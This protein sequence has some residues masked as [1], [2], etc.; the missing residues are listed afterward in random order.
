MIRVLAVLVLA[1]ATVAVAGIREIAFDAASCAAGKTLFTQL[2]PGV[3]GIVVQNTY[4]DP[5]MWGKRYREYMGGA[6]GSGIAVGDYDGDGKVDLFVSTKTKPGR[7][8]RNLGHWKFADVTERAGLS[9]NDSVLSAGLGWLKGQLGSESPSI[10]HQGATFADV[11]N[12]GRPDLYVCRNNAPNLLYMNNGDGT[13][14]EE[15]AERGLALVDGSVVGA[16][17]DYD[18]DGR[19]D[20]FVL[21]NQVNGTEPSGRADHLFHNDGTGH[22]TE[23]TVQAGIKGGTFGHSATW[24]DY[25]HDGWPDLYI[26]NDFGGPDHL[27]RN[28]HDGTFTD[29]LDAVVP[30]TSYSSMGADTA[31]LNN[32]GYPDLFVADMAT[33]NREQDRRGLAASRESMLLMDLNGTHAPQYMRN[34]LLLNTGR[35]VFQEA[36]C[37]AGIA[38]TGWTWSV[39]FE[40]FDNDGWVD[41]HVTNGMV[42][43]ANNSD[44]LN[45]MMQA[46]SDAGRI[47]TMKNTPVLNEPHLAYR[48]RNGEGFDNVSAA[49]GLNETGVSFG[50]ATGDFDNDGDLDLVYLNYDGGVSVF[51]NDVANQHRIQVRLR[52]K[53]SNRFGVGAVI[54][55][56]SEAGPQM[57]TLTVSRGYASGSE[58]V[59]HF[60]LGRDLIVK[61]LSVEW[62]SG[63]TQSFSSLAADRAY[64]IEEEDAPSSLSSTTEIVPNALYVVAGSESGAR[65]K[66]ASVLA[67]PDKEQIFLPFR[68]DQRG[69]GIVAGDVD[70]DGIEDLLVTATPGSPAQLLHA[71]NGHYAGA[72]LPG[73]S[74]ASVEDGPALLLDFDGDGSRDLLVT[75]TGAHRDSWPD[76]YQPVLYANDGHGHFTRSDLLPKMAV[77][78]G[79]ICAADWDGDGDLDLFI[80]ARSVPGRY[81]E[82]PHSYLLRREGAHFVDVSENAPWLAHLG[83]VKSALFRDVDLD[84]RPDLIVASEWDFVRYFHNDGGGG[85]SDRTERAGFA[86]GGRG[87][88]N[89]LA[90]ADLNGDGRPDF[91]AGNL[92]LNTTYAATRDHPTLL[93]SGDFANDGT[94]LLI[95]A[96]YGG[97]NVYPVRSR[98][99]LGN[100]LPFVLR[101]FPRN[102]DFARATL[103]SVVGADALATAEVFK[104]DQFSSGAFLSQPDGTYR[105]TSFPRIAQIGP[106]QGIVAAD[107]DG[108]G[109]VDVC[110]VQ[111]SYNALPHFDGGVGIFL[112]GAGDGTFTA[113][114]PAASGVIVPGNA[115]A[116][117]LIGS[118]TG[119][120][121]DLFVTR[122]SGTSELLRNQVSGRRWLSLRLVGTPANRDAIGAR[123][124]VAYSDG[125]QLVSEIGAGGGWLSQSA[126]S[127]LIATSSKKLATKVT[128]RW[129]EGAVTEHLPPAEQSGVWLVK[130][131]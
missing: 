62:P 57:R 94:K 51:R 107:L 83:L 18:R 98:G 31:D 55:I 73:L 111:N 11:D 47:R 4:D 89:S 87:W 71:E 124:T 120:R 10:W 104:A 42:R 101:R 66:D 119:A 22:F 127:L 59:A 110:A 1:H 40:D 131:K 78:A 90:S 74:G 79:A 117:V 53:R 121:P 32:D 92:G 95:E 30:H 7:L 64:L 126:S 13:F 68:T 60:G 38:A 2:P 36:A 84:G 39:L 44:I 72:P 69:P 26:A 9:E 115:K 15:A 128:V 103:S 109:V 50:A 123:V 112:K 122:F 17:C 54:R 45:R 24:F 86:S 29:V 63:A 91:V 113:I 97:E 93:Y 5:Q 81:P 106:M 37:W 118:D 21:T 43:E 46:E 25:D 12:D 61:R 20:V 19:L 108:D 34:S 88:W 48:N 76:G 67:S 16:F 65:I 77:N 80:G 49:W 129:P 82:A 102:D 99:D 28:N 35:G 100:R 58:L 96:A 8:F 23:T 70:G 116:L 14:R 3:T 41:L 6:M 27:Y 114:A 105:F 75:K 52:G 85:F 56:E 130:A 125:S 33:T